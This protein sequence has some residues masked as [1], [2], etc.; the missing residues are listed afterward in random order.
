MWD[1]GLGGG[2]ATVVAEDSLVLTKTIIGLTQGED[3]LF[4][5]R[6]RNVYGYGEFSDFVTIRASSVPDTMEMVNTV[7]ASTDI[8]IAWQAPPNGGDD[9][10]AYEVE[11][12]IPAT[13]SYAV[14]VTYC[15]NLDE[16]MLQCSIPHAHLIDT[17][18][19][20]VGDILKARVKAYNVNGW[21]D[22]SQLN[23]AGS[24]VQ[25]YPQKMFTPTEGTATTVDQIQVNW[26]ALTTL[27]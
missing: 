7:V 27:E 16:T 21:G 3:Y 12:Y 8:F 5:V 19:F 18:A 1:N 15:D 25:S 2:D 14:D 17:Y 20:Q 13:G 23:T 22:P 11:L 26:Q 9:I 4:K 10:T 24:I 6:A